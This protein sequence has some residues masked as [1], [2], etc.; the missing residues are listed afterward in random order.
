[1]RLGMVVGVP[2]HRDEHMFDLA[3]EVG[4][5]SRRSHRLGRQQ[6]N[7]VDERDLEPRY[8]L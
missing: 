8:G 4:L 5:R 2:L 3:Q 6:R 1:V 7:R